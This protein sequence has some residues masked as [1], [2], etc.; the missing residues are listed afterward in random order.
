MAKQHYVPQLV[1]RN[2]ATISGKEKRIHVFDKQTETSYCA[3]VS[4]V[5]AEKGFYDLE[6]DE[7]LKRIEDRVGIVIKKI[8]DKESLINL[9]DG[10]KYLLSEFIAIQITRVK[11]IRTEM[12]KLIK[13]Q[14]GKLKIGTTVVELESSLE[15]IVR[16]A[17]M[18]NI[19]N[20]AYIPY[21]HDKL[22]LLFKTKETCPFYT[23]DN[24]ITL[25]CLH[26][27]NFDSSGKYEE[28]GI[29]VK[30]IEIY[31]PISKTLSLGIF[32]KN[33]EDNIRNRYRKLKTFKTLCK[34][35]PDFT[36]KVEAD[37]TRHERL[38]TGL[39]TGQAIPSDN[40]NVI[41]INSLQVKSSSRFV[42][43]C[44][45]NFDL[46]RQMLKENPLFKHGPRMSI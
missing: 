1:L 16:I 38:I 7:D 19:G 13:N 35:S 15:E 14:N 5:S 29:A 10:E 32:C 22:W 11:H 24:P 39:E 41:N 45:D 46:V 4:D 8:I 36:K 37:K 9:A 23:S 30:D 27:N 34:V 3:R 28:L 42:Y 33:N 12:L 43:S 2:F 25:Q 26:P 6:V 20:P 17:S 21:I 40:D 44:T 31:L 18:M